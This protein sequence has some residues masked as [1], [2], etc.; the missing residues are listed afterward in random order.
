MEYIYTIGF[1]VGMVTIIGVIIDIVR[2]KVRNYSLGIAEIVFGILL[3]AVTV[4]FFVKSDIDLGYFWRRNRHWIKTLLYI[5]LG[6][7]VA[8]GLVVL[9]KKKGKDI[10]FTIDR[11]AAFGIG[12]MVSVVLMGIIVLTTLHDINENIDSLSHRIRD[13]EN[14]TRRIESYSSDFYYL[15]S[16]I[17]NLKSSIDELKSDV[18]RIKDELGIKDPIYWNGRWY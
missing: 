3:I 10:T 6:I 4:A 8:I 13:I 1:C 9:Y 5:L 16:D 11:I 2:K 7:A 14:D 18:D 17:D 15:K 12:C